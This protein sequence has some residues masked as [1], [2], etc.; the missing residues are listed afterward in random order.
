MQPDEA[1]VLT[2]DRFI[3]AA[4]TFDQNQRP[5]VSIELDPAGGRAMR[6]IT[7]ENLHHQMAII[8][9][10]RGKGEAISVATIQGEFSSRFQITGNFSP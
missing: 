2:G 4:S 9:I 8:L 1:V 3:G 10:E 6:E 5:A 7:R